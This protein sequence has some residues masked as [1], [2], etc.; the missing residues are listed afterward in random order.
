MAPERADAE[1]LPRDDEHGVGGHV[2]EVRSVVE[3]DAAPDVEAA[4]QRETGAAQPGAATI[5]DEE[6]VGGGRVA[7]DEIIDPVMVGVGRELCAR[8][9]VARR[10]VELKAGSRA[11]DQGCR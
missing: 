3:C 7:F 8:E 11:S 6:D 4:F 10:L 2:I 5:A 9:R 1:F